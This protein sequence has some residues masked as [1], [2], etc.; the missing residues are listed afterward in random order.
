MARD[1]SDDAVPLLRRILDEQPSFDDGWLLLS[2]AL[3]E[4]GHGDEAAD[5]LLQ[6]LEQKP[7][8]VRARVQLAELYEHQRRWAQAAETW[9]KVQDANQRNT[10]DC[11]STGIRAAQRRQ[12]C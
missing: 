2:S 10:D 4:S 8:L 5:A 1:R 12:A 11:G 9:A 6:A 7:S 3:E